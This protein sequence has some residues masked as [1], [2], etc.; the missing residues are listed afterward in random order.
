M[1]A[2]LDEIPSEVWKAWKFDDLLFWYCNMNTIERWTKGWILLFPWKGDIGIAKNYQ[3]ITL[4]NIAAKIYNALLLNCIQP[5]IE[6]ILRKNQNCFRRNWSTS[7]ILTICWIL[8]VCMENL[9][10]HSDLYVSPRCFISYTEGRWS[11]YFLPV[12]SPPKTFTAIMMS[13]KNIKVKVHATD[14][15]IDSFDVVVGVV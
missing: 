7:Q 1:A 3:G 12:V 15:D 8:G 14:E 10:W 2:D 11:K 5:E 4:T 6:K 13:Y 9:G